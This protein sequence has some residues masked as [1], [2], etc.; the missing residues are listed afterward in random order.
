CKR[1][2]KVSWPT[3]IRRPRSHR[4]ASA[5]RRLPWPAAGGLPNR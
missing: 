3:T 1:S 5:V 2:A 4:A